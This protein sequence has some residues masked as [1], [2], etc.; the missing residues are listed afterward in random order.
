MKIPSDATSY[1]PPVVPLDVGAF[2]D[3]AIRHTVR[4][5][6]TE[7]WL[8][9]YTLGGS[10]LFRFSGGEHHSEA[11][12]V[13]LF[14]PGVY[15]D[16]RYAPAAKGWQLLFA[17]FLPRTEWLSWFHWPELAPG[18][19]LLSITDRLVA[20]QVTLQLREATRW[21]H[22][23]GP[24]AE[25]LARNC[26]ERALLCC[27]SV[28]PQPARREIDPR[29]GKAMDYLVTSPERPFSEQA[30]ARHAG[31]SASRLRHIFRE[32]TGYSPRDFLERERIR[33]AK[34]LLVLSRLSIGE[35]AGQLG[36]NNA[37]YFSARFRRS[38]GESP[39]AFRQ[40]M[41]AMDHR[42]RAGV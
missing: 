1:C 34:D 32:E 16:Y 35:I 26:F 21:R 5:R 31:L 37:F 38:I 42:S 12:E 27:D 28:N 22:S 15:Q 29:V 9:I 10:G 14:S 40:R 19:R 20:R 7:D 13:V 25:E 11:G 3:R 36:F 41:M 33:R 23:S 2:R 6:G 18:M 8:L 39:R 30:L 17:H 24:R 4:P